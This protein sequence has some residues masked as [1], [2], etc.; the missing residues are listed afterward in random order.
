MEVY[1]AKSPPPFTFFDDFAEVIS[2]LSVS[3]SNLLICG[4]FNI[5]VNDC[6]NT[7]ARKFQDLIYGLNLQ[8]HVQFPTHVHGHTLDLVLT[9]DDEN[10]LFMKP[11]MIGHRLSD[12]DTIL[13]HVNLAKSEP[14]KKEILYRKLRQI[15]IGKFR[16][17]LLDLKLVTGKTSNIDV[18]LYNS[19]LSGLLD[20][21]APLRKKVMSVREL[22]P[23][24]NNN[25]AQEKKLRR[26]K[27]RIWR[28]AKSTDSWNQYKLQRNKV[29]K[30]LNDSKRN[31]FNN[32]IEQ[33]IYNTKELFKIMNG[34]LD[35]TKKNPLPDHS[36]SLDL[37]NEFNNFFI[38]KI[39]NI[40]EILDGKNN[41]SDIPVQQL[42]DDEHNIPLFESFDLI[43]AE[44]LRKMVMK[45]PSKSCD[46]DPIPTQILK[47]CID[48][49]AEPIT[50]ITNSMLQSGTF[51]EDLK[52]A[53]VSPLLKKIT[54]ELIK[55][56]YR[57]VSN[58]AFIGK[59]NEKIVANQFMRHC[60][61]NGIR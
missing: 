24:Y 15:D 57:P 51:S 12:H 53:L 36:S 39:K 52:M 50:K 56:N 44:D 10:L 4:D 45:L 18:A 25:I 58:L 40:R 54:L 33:N 29:S 31:Y 2:P 60:K 41:I 23:W 61:D 1:Q 37:A 28:K 49:L 19:E 8:Q 9:V 48:I 20:V 34:L 32:L 21:H 30:L 6:N 43:S 5:H 17:D 38:D 13:I 11:P 55:S 46:L 16:K 59:L 27:E 47:E 42:E 35:N 7:Y 26:K 3:S 14:V 22:R